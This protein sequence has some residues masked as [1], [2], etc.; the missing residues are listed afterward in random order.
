M[1]KQTTRQKARLAAS[2]VQG[3][4]RRERAE[5][6]RR[7]EKLAFEVLAALGER[8]ATIRHRARSSSTESVIL[9]TVSRDTEAP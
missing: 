2:Q 3:K 5:R 1:G 8:D 4:C 9:E 7:L 6:D